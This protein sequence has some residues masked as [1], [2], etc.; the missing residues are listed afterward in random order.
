MS[1]GECKDLKMILLV[2][3][4]LKMGTGKIAAQCAHAALGMFRD[5]QAKN[6]AQLKQWLDT[7]QMKVVCRVDTEDAMMLIADNARKMGIPVHIVHD[8]GHTQVESG[9]KT[10]AALGPSAADLLNRVTGHLKL[11]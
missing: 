7:G 9:S 3:R 4:D 10:V 5:L 11:L 2:R 8:A 6:S 1:T